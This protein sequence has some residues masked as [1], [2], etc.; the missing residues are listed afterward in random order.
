MSVFRP[1]SSV[2][3]NMPRTIFHLDLDA[4]FCAVEELRNPALRGKAFVVGGNPQERGV[5]SSASY[6]ARAKGA[7][8]AM[9][10]A[11]AM[12]L[13]PGL[14]IVPPTRGIYGQY[15][16]QV[17]ALL[18]EYTLTLQQL[19]IDEA[20]LDMTEFLE[21]SR[22]SPR[23]L[24][25]EIQGRIKNEISLP[26]SIG[27][28]TSKLVA[29]MASGAAKPNG[30]KVI[31]PGEEAIFLAPM[32]VGEL[33]GVGQVTAARLNALGILTIGDLQRAPAPALAGV[34]GRFATQVSERARGIDASAVESAREVKSIS[35]ERT[36]ARDVADR[37]TLR[38]LLL[39]LS[40]EVAA[41]LRANG[42][43]AKTIQLKLRWH[44]FNTITRQSTLAEPTQL[45][46][47]IFGA[48][49]PLWLGAWRTG[50]RVR[51]LGVG[52]SG[53]SEGHQLG[54]FGADEREQKLALARVVDELREQYG[55]DAI[56]RAILKKKK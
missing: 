2:S 9:P 41:R 10:T 24:A 55:K 15:S 27:V 23:E 54:M 52:A 45:G 53:L 33:W 48:V 25:L 26:A 1:R 19:S 3:Q 47:E 7:R 35:E 6:P 12:R 31:A 56:Q 21:K 37:A 42:L 16:A 40:D 28:A 18:R 50:E 8:N 49:E 39:Q 46:E 5:V 51:L 43:F 29:K 30:V 34:F 22:V 14:I 11:Q 17:M 32:Q 44:D 4:F 20:F 38:N 13:C 36:F